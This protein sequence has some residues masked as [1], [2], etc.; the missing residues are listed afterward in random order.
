M[1]FQWRDKLQEQIHKRY[2]HIMQDW[3]H[4]KWGMSLPRKKNSGIKIRA[5]E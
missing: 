2:G 1:C 4:T 3:K 5:R